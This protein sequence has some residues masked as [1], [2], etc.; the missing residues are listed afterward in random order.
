M[1]E[2][3]IG[4]RDLKRE[5]SAVLRRVRS[6]EAVVVTDRNRPVAALVPVGEAGAG[7]ALRQLAAAGLISWKGGKPRGL[8]RPARVKGAAVAAAVVEDRR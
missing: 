1:P 4:V 5:L 6:G 7:D 3:M 8:A 2:R